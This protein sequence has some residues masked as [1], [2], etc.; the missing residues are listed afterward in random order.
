MRIWVIILSY[1]TV[2][3]SLSCGRWNVEKNQRCY[4]RITSNWYSN[5]SKNVSCNRYRF[6]EANESKILRKFCGSLEL[7]E[8]WSWNVLKG[9]ASVKRKGTTGKVVFCLKFLEEEKLTFQCAV[10]KFVSDHDIPLKFV[11]NLDEIPL[12]YVSPRKYIFD[13]K[14]S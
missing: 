3:T 13:L 12:S 8:C 9:M 5:F 6:V 2:L 10:S 7:T 14:G 1:N 11:L 4:Y